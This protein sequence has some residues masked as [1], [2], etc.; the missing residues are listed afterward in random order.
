MVGEPA[1]ARILAG[2]NHSAD[3]TRNAPSSAADGSTDSASDVGHERNREPKRVA[4]AVI[5][6]LAG[7][8][9]KAIVNRLAEV[10]RSRRIPARMSNRIGLALT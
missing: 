4:E 10:L 1:D 9:S 2:R 8:V 3:Q 5:D 7:R 6:S